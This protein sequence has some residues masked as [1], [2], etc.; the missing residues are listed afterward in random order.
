MDSSKIKAELEARLA[1]LGARVTDI[2]GDLRAPHTRDSEDRA[3]E[4][5]NDEV[6]EGLE[7]TALDEI[8]QIEQALKR[9]ESGDYGTCATCGKS[10]GERRLEA[11]P[12]T[13]LCVNCAA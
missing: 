4:I 12:Y 5:E 7:A 3:T 6:L 11:V 13:V 8:D 2:E 10:I 9:L 1:V